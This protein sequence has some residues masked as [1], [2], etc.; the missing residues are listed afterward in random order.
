VLARVAGF[1]AS[2]DAVHITAPDRT[3]AGL[4]RAARAALG[5]AGIGP[6]Q[7]D[8]V[9]AHATA[10]SF[11]D[12]M[13]SRALAALG[14]A[15]AVVHPFKA[16]IGHTLGAAGVLEALAAADALASGTAPAAAGGEDGAPVDPDAPA[17]LLAR[18]ER[19]ELGAALKL[20]AAFGG[21]NAALVLV[22]P[23]LPSRRPARL[24]RAVYLRASAHVEDV[25]LVALSQETGVARERLARLDVL[26]RL[27]VSAVAALARELGVGGLAGAGIVAG[28]ALATIDTNEGYDA[29]RRARGPTAVEPRVFPS[30]SPNALTGECAIVFKLT[31]PSFS[32]GAGLDG[33]MEALGA[34][35]E[36]VA[37]GDAERM[38]VVAAD[39]AGPAARDLI[40]LAG[41]QGRPLARGAAAL[42]LTTD[43]AQAVREV[44]I[45]A[46]VA[47]DGGGPVGHLSL[48]RWLRG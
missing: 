28:H 7:I 19:R 12:A 39:D 25:D 11:N 18:T 17:M 30:T 26:C 31:G 45:D 24:R 44:A 48:L 35:A 23:D 41:W 29:R 8:L 46:P 22:R 21:T 14:V 32:V 10:T 47:H 38:V 6:S 37:C 16:Q 42:L 20:S 2:N 43:A 34:A 40:Q 5:D 13:E 33:A 4:A 3:G 15:D 27:G 36:L 9:S 1:G